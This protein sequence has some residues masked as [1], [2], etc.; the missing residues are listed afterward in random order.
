[1]RGVPLPAILL[2]DAALSQFRQHG[3]DEI[4]SGERIWLAWIWRP[5]I[6]GLLAA[7]HKTAAIYD[8]LLGLLF[9]VL[10]CVVFRLPETILYITSQKRTQEATT[11]Q[12]NGKL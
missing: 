8:W 3:E 4:P 10:Q 6:G 1:M 5:I 7:R 12:R 9:T 2:L 11:H